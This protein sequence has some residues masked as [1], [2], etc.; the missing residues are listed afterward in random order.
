MTRDEEVLSWGAGMTTAIVGIA[1]ALIVLQVPPLLVLAWALVSI[2]T[3]LIAEEELLLVIVRWIRRLEAKKKD[4]SAGDDVA[5]PN[6]ARYPR[7]RRRRQIELLVILFF[8]SLTFVPRYF[9]GPPIDS[10]PLT[11]PSH[12]DHLPGN[13]DKEKLANAPS[14]IKELTLRMSP[15]L[16]GGLLAFL[17]GT[18]RAQAHFSWWPVG[19]LG[20]IVL[21][22]AIIAIALLLRKRPKEAAPLGALGLAAVVLR[23]PAEFSHLNELTFYLL[24]ALLVGVTIYLIW[25]CFRKLNAQLGTSNTQTND[26]PSDK[27]KESPDAPI[28]IVFSVFVLLWSIIAVAY[29]AV[30]SRAEP[31]NDPGSTGNTTRESEA[32]RVG[33]IERL[34]TV[35]GFGSKAATLSESDDA[36]QR[37]QT[38]LAKASLQPKDV[39]LLIGS[40]D[41]SAIRRTRDLTNEKL[42]EQRVSQIEF[43]AKKTNPDMQVTTLEIDQPSDCKPSEKLRAV[44]PAVIRLGEKSK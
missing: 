5:V 15:A 18:V 25:L 21:G 20:A 16:E 7:F 10:S 35:S 33:R 14:E 36:L 29:H 3:L 6:Y 37:F 42:A 13:P 30:P 34:P 43:E 26:G 4:N 17:A 28:T 22:V 24:F 39:L 38:D 1:V 27:D 23:N 8:A 32:T 31:T 9:D 41:C 11:P 19:T 40:S 2:A 12:S 44:F